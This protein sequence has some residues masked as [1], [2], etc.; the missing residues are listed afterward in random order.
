MTNKKP[1]A[2]IVPPEK[3]GK[4][5]PPRILE[6]RMNWM[7]IIISVIIIVLLMG[8]ATMFFTV[9]GIWQEYIAT[10]STSYQDLVNKVNEQNIKI[11]LLLQQL[12]N[13]NTKLPNESKK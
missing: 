4:I 6:E 5:T 1:E 10:R 13:Y 3:R 8:F 11:D 12:Q 9:G 7:W 2:Q